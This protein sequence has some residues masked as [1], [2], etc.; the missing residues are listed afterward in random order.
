MK[1][2]WKSSECWHTA[3]AQALALC[4]VFGLIGTND[5]K[6]L[7]E[8]AVKCVT[9]VFALCANGYVVLHY[10]RGRFTLR[11]IDM[12]DQEMP[13]NMVKKLNIPSV[14]PFWLIG[15]TA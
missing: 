3:I 7:E 1:P 2:G 15:S 13:T 6:S 5:S 8:A 4:T 12:D 9:A 10:I 14:M 11:K